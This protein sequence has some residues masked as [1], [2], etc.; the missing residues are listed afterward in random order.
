[1]VCERTEAAPSLPTREDIADQIRNERMSMLARR[2]LRDIRL[3]A[4]VDIRV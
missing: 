2:Y 3:A 4:I 1:M